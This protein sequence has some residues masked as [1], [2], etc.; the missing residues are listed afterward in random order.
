MA[1]EKLPTRQAYYPSSESSKCLCRRHAC[2]NAATQQ[3]VY[4]LAR[5]D[6]FQRHWVAKLLRSFNLLPVYRQRDQGNTLT[7]NER[8]FLAC[9]EIL[10]K[11]QAVLLFPEANQEMKY[12]LRPLKKG[13]AR[14]A[15]RA[16]D[17]RGLDVQIVPVGLHF[18][19]YTR[20]RSVV[21]VQFGDP[22]SAQ[23]YLPSYRAAPNQAIRQITLDLQTRLK[24]LMLHISPPT[25]YHSLSSLVQQQARETL[26][27]KD[28]WTDREAFLT[29][30]DTANRL[31]TLSEKERLTDQ[32]STVV[33]KVER[34]AAS[35][36]P[37]SLW[38]FIL[39]AIPA[40]GG[41]IMHFLPWILTD[42]IVKHTVP[43]KH[44]YTSARVLTRMIVVSLFYL[45]YTILACTFFPLMIGLS[46]PLILLLLGHFTLRFLDEVGHFRRSDGHFAGS[47]RSEKVP[48]A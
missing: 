26:E 15:L 17:K 37:V 42:L 46:F 48:M 2:C 45:L 21:Q 29:E 33:K 4:F 44:F 32:S 27:M 9:E 22:L 6:I 1:V 38:R 47:L 35:A 5:A 13:C 43:H 28:E 25:H 39:L 24:S 19:H 23:A 7:Q 11:G 8:V 12:A 20:W 41:G 30:Q 10:A 16:A 36:R 3:Q 31:T 18:H 40:L 34:L 14:I